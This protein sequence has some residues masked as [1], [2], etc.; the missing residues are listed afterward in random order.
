MKVQD[1]TLEA[2]R[3]EDVRGGSYL[4]GNGIAQ[5]SYNGGASGVSVVGGGDFNLSPVS[6][7]SSVGQANDTQQSAGIQDITSHSFVLGIYGSQ[8]ELGVFGRGWVR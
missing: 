6:V 8:L 4:S 2:D 3:L 5:N 1:L 7:A